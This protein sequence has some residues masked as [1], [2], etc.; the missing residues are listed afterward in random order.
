MSANSATTAA[1]IQLLF[2]AVVCAK[3]LVGGRLHRQLLVLDSFPKLI[4]YWMEFAI[5]CVISL[6]V[7]QRFRAG[8]SVPR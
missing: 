6:K 5:N 2:V 1:R 7:G 4:H 3:F 8:K